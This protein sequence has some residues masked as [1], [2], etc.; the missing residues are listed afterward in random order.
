MFHSLYFVARSPREVYNVESNEKAGFGLG[1]LEHTRASG[2]IQRVIG[3]SSGV[4]LV[5]R[6][7]MR[8]HF[9]FSL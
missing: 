3:S 5:L 9:L 8:K 2:N 1:G 6:Y 4:H 7:M